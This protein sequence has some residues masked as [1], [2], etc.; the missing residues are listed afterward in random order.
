[1]R[2][3]D[4]EKFFG[5][6]AKA[7]EAIGIGR[8]NFTKWKKQNKGIVPANHAVRF[9]IKSGHKL[10]MGWDDYQQDQAETQQAA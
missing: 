3:E 10:D 5:N 7:S 6:A 8:C 1:M 2:I 4:V 9:V